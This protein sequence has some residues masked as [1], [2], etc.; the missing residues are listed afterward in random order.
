MNLLN[1]KFKPNK[2]W[3]KII[4]VLKEE[5]EKDNNAEVKWEEHKLDWQI[6]WS[7]CKIPLWYKWILNERHKE[8]TKLEINERVDQILEESIK[9]TSSKNSSVKIQEKLIWNAKENNLINNKIFKNAINH[10]IN[11][12]NLLYQKLTIKNDSYCKKFIENI[13]HDQKELLDDHKIMQEFIETKDINKISQI[14]KVI[15]NQEAKK[16]KMKETHKNFEEECR[17]AEIW[18]PPTPDVYNFSLQSVDLNDIEN[19]KIIAYLK[20]TE[21]FEIL[22][23][24]DSEKKDIEVLASYK[25]F[26]ELECFIKIE[27]EENKFITLK[28]DLESINTNSAASKINFLTLKNI[29]VREEDE[30]INFKLYVWKFNDEI[31]ERIKAAEDIVKSE[32]VK[33]IGPIV[34]LE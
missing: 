9:E 33:F 6:Y 23:K 28:N 4:K 7:D 1:L 17:E 2:E 34:K 32:M 27:V 25:S 8:H 15:K 29:Q 16:A 30:T 22:F 18:I 5:E 3:N 26:D 24:Y 12:L 31:R 10:Y 13:T 21:A 14:T 11:K 19:K 20:G